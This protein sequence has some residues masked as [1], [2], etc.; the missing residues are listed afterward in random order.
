MKYV[1][2]SSIDDAADP[3]AK[4]ATARHWTRTY[5]CAAA[6]GRVYVRSTLSKGLSQGG[7]TLKLKVL[8]DEYSVGLAAQACGQPTARPLYG[9]LPCRG[10]FDAPLPIAC[11]SRTFQHEPLG[12]PRSSHCLHAPP[13]ARA[14]LTSVINLKYVM[15]CL[16]GHAQ[17]IPRILFGSL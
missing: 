14:N 10:M 2:G 13:T 11:T 9:G 12:S 4:R 3:T 5:H 15:T 8:R 16:T 7:K 6:G 1:I 17:Q